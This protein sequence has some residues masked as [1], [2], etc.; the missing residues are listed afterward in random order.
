L[1]QRGENDEA[2]INRWDA[3]ERFYFEN[4]FATEGVSFFVDG[5]EAK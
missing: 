1:H 4:L 3:A 5:S 2:W